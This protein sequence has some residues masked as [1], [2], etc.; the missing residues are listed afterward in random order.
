M[1]ESRGF[2]DKQDW[3]SPTSLFDTSTMDAVSS[4]SA[5]WAD[6]TNMFGLD[7]LASQV[8]RHGIV[9]FREPCRKK[10][11]PNSLIVK[12]ELTSV[13]KP[14]IELQ[15]QLAETVSHDAFAAIFA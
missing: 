11:I 10:S 13:K 14:M 1:P 15:Q 8:M 5:C 9:V 12:A 6:G 7:R 3:T 4:W 2:F